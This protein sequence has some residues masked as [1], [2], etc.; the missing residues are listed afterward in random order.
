MLENE[1]PL[2]YGISV[3]YLRDPMEYLNYGV[4]IRKVRDYASKVSIW[5][6]MNLPNSEVP[7]GPEFEEEM[8]KAGVAELS[9]RI[10]LLESDPSKA[11]YEFQNFE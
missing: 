1:V 5:L 3:S 7:S 8:R 10:A 9:P 6:K 2:H 11:G 4:H